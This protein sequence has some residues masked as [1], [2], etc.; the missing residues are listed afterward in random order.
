MAMNDLPRRTSVVIAAPN[1]R[2]AEKLRH[3]SDRLCILDSV[4]TLEEFDSATREHSPEVALV[5]AALGGQDDC[6]SAIRGLTGSHSKTRPA[7]VLDFQDCELIVKAF[8]AGAHGV[9]YYG[10]SG[11]TICAAVQAIARGR[12]YA[13][14]EELELLLASMAESPG[15]ADAA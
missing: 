4:A 10:Q 8:A 9:I 7:L 12:I 6:L 13:G 11:E 15:Q 1:V 3:Y 5:A 2:L 14:P